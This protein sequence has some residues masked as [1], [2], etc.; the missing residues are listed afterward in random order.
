M[1]V[2]EDDDPYNWDVARVIQELC[3]SNRTW[4]APPAARL[5]DPDQLSGKLAELA[6]DGETLLTFELDWGQG[7]LRDFFRNDLGIKIPAH[8]MSMRKAVSQFQNRSARFREKKRTQ[9]GLDSEVDEKPEPLPNG[10]M[11]ISVTGR[12]ATRSISPASPGAQ[13]SKESGHDLL[14]PPLV[15]QTFPVVNG[16]ATAASSMLAPTSPAAASGDHPSPGDH[17]DQPPKKKQRIAPILQSTVPSGAKSNPIFT[18]ADD[19]V[20]YR[21]V[22]VNETGRSDD[23]SLS[24]YGSRG[25]TLSNMFQADSDSDDDDTINF[26]NTAVD[27]PGRRRLANGRLKRYL[28]QNS[29]SKISGAASDGSPESVVPLLGESDEEID[30]DTFKEW[31]KEIAQR[32]KLE[33]LKRTFLS[34][35][36]VDDTIEVAIRSFEE[37][38]NQEKKPREL[39]KANKLWRDARRHHS[40]QHQISQAL[41]FCRSLDARIAKQTRAYRQDHWSSREALIKQMANVEPS[42]HQRQAERFRITILSSAAEP[43]KPR[44]LPRPAT[45]K[46]TVAR[47]DS[48]EET[49][50]SDSEDG[51]DQFIIND[52]PEQAP[53]DDM[54]TSILDGT[55][56]A[57]LFQVDHHADVQSSDADDVPMAED[58]TSDSPPQVA[59]PAD[60]P[61]G[62][63]AGS[64]IA[65][66][67]LS[68]L[69]TS[70]TATSPPPEGTRQKTP[71]TNNGD[72]DLTM[73]ENV[74]G[75][76]DMELPVILK[77]NDI[78][79]TPEVPKHPSAADIEAIA[80]LGVL[81]WANKARGRKGLLIALL[82]KWPADLR[83]SLQTAVAESGGEE[84]ESFWQN[85][86]ASAKAEAET[87]HPVQ[88]TTMESRVTISL[89]Q[90]YISWV[91]TSDFAYPLKDSLDLNVFKDLERCHK[92]YRFNRF[93][94]L[95]QRV[96]RGFADVA[97]SESQALESEDAE[98]SSQDLTQRSGVTAEE[99]DMDDEA[100]ETEGDDDMPISPSKK[101]RLARKRRKRRL[102]ARNI[103]A[104]DIRETNFEQKALFEGKRRRLREELA[105]VVPKDMARFI[106]NETKE[107]DEELIYINSRARPN[108]KAHQVEGVRFMWNQ[109]VVKSKVRQGCLLAHTMGLGKTMQVITLLVAMAE[110]SSSENEAVY[111]QIPRELRESRT[112]ILCP[113]GLV[114]NWVDEL[115]IWT[116]E[117]G[118]GGRPLQDNEVGSLGLVYKIDRTLANDHRRACVLAWKAT[119]GVLVMGY[120]MFLAFSK[121]PELFEVLGKTPNIVIADEAHKLK[122]K[123]SQIHNATQNFQAAC[124]IAMTGS[125]LTNNVADYYHMISWVAPNYLG[126]Y[127]EFK[128]IYETP[129]T[130]L[131]ADST[132]GDRR[133]AV[134]ALNVLR[135][136]VSPLVHRMGI[137]SLKDDLPQKKEFILYLSLTP[138]QL[139]AYTSFLQQIIYNSEVRERHGGNTGIWTFVQHLALLLAHPSIYQKRLKRPP[140]AERVSVPEVSGD[141][142]PISPDEEA[143][144]ENAGDLKISEDVK[145]L[146]LA[147]VPTRQIQDVNN[148]F[149]I[150]ILNAI[151]DECKK[152]GDKVLVFS[153]H[154]P[155]LDFLEEMFRRQMRNYYRLDGKTPI[156][157]RQKD[158]KRFND[159]ENTEVYLISTRAGG[160]G[161]NIHGANRVVIFDFKY[162]P[163]EE[164]QA[165]GRAYRIGQTKPV[166]VYWLIV[167]ETFESSIQNRSVFKT[168]LASRVVDKK[169]PISWSKRAVDLFPKD[170]SLPSVPPRDAGIPAYVGKDMVLDALLESPKLGESIRK[171]MMTE[172]F[173]EEEP[174]D[175]VLTADDRKEITEW[176]A[177]NHQRGVAGYLEQLQGSL[178][179]QYPSGTPVLLPQ[180]RSSESHLSSTEVKH[181]DAQQQLTK[182]RVITLKVPPHMQ[183]RPVQYSPV[184]S[185]ASTSTDSHLKPNATVPSTPASTCKEF[186]LLRP[187]ASVSSTLM[188]VPNPAPDMSNGSSSVRTQNGVVLSTAQPTSGQ[189][190]SSSSTAH[191]RESLPSFGGPPPLAQPESTNRANATIPGINL[192]S[193]SRPALIHRPVG[194]PRIS[195][196]SAPSKEPI[197]GT[198]TEFAPPVVE[199]PTLF[200]RADNLHKSN[201]S[202]KGRFLAMLYTTFNAMDE[203]LKR[204]I[205][206]PDQFV[207]DL[208]A[209]IKSNP[210]C[211]DLISQYDVWTSLVKQ[212]EKHPL[213]G[214]AILFGRV[215][216]GELGNMKREERA[217]LAEDLGKT[218]EATLPGQSGAD[219][220]PSHR[221]TSTHGSGFPPNAVV[222]TGTPADRPENQRPRDSVSGSQQT[223]G[224]TT[225]PAYKSALPGNF[226]NCRHGL[227][228]HKQKR[229]PHLP[230]WAQ[231]AVADENIERSKSPQNATPMP[232]QRPGRPIPPPRRHSSQHQQSSQA[233]RGRP[234]GIRNK[235]GPVKPSPSQPARSQSRP[236]GPMAGDSADNA[237]V[238]D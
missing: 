32:E 221:H 99:D 178:F 102:I 192:Q 107:D 92:A 163:M 225:T 151:L 98:T 139:T 71:V 29:T 134:K 49:L 36:E 51:L 30:E 201:H 26:V 5:P 43:P 153:Q 222:P 69:P 48:D 131:H 86:V 188:H 2:R 45:R 18:A 220:E 190:F 202:K 13:L 129:V 136:T 11:G 133:R 52:E 78:P 126:P 9:S 219:K 170:G 64:D 72:N 172:T 93:Y 111:K 40:R 54:D 213:Y 121:T 145:S 47:R 105:D 186:L 22:T 101:T 232:S 39:L 238:I 187:D 235:S 94:R 37:A 106:I 159:D 23:T 214:K 167:S 109:I 209:A 57:S 135:E 147:T 90:L 53:A 117:R 84:A 212:L 224:G 128:Q 132:P 158:V 3:T 81:Y 58:Q 112:L 189:G 31:E 208:D 61:M 157:T 217:K 124:R 110:A 59:L 143:P 161:L 113:A 164:Q 196:P 44:T 183:T 166:F 199:K 21:P 15:V 41:K 123:T 185:P 108:I 230:D 8:Q 191:G 118:P 175:S 1:D 97:P 46:K 150:L 77:A 83:A 35:D 218:D 141:G 142:T 24:Y 70:Y 125:P 66:N 89:V 226:E 104:A 155:T 154:F 12:G 205:Q 130:G 168:Q 171:I 149:K 79:H 75:P 127:P 137:L 227:S 165:I 55:L 28:L 103:E 91:E 223:G 100:Q 95:L 169:N 67:G 146:L 10:S 204:R 138:V 216:P 180:P 156:N 197:A 27:H 203:D 231:K 74:D 56:L 176:V 200:P 42:V 16:Q 25:Y 207:T 60:D 162:S 119:G 152:I 173:E 228:T 233:R 181:P 193:T 20:V 148:S 182:P 34:D 234:P 73:A 198:G 85:R 184:P 115:N 174:D 195:R 210:D 6:V 68:Q 122:G 65:P 211:Q 4:N 63:D 19:V 229:A 114:D 116:P 33:A 96:L 160:E 144:A 17:Q 87:G 7:S 38:W 120:P 62:V 236:S 237:V 179:S 140:K 88:G 215:K 206:V 50:T 177:K 194:R 76:G 14:P 80:N 82:S